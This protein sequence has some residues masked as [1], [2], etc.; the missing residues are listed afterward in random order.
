MSG[1]RSART[2]ATVSGAVLVVLLITV[3]ALAPCLEGLAFVPGGQSI[4]APAQRECEPGEVKFRGTTTA[5]QEATLLYCG[6]F[7]VEVQIDEIIDNRCG[8]LPE[9]QTISVFYDY[10]LPPTDPWL[11][12]GEK[13]EVLGWLHLPYGP[14]SCWGSVVAN[15][16]GEYIKRI[17]EGTPTPAPTCDPTVEITV[18]RGE[19]ATY[20]M[21]DPIEVCTQVSCPTHTYEEIYSII[22]DAPPT[23]ILSGWTT[24]KECHWFS[25]GEP[26]GVHRLRDETLEGATDETW[27][28]ASSCQEPTVTPTPTPVVTPEPTLPPSLEASPTATVT[29]GPTEAPTATPTVGPAPSPAPTATPTPAP[30]PDDG[31]GDGIPDA[32]DN[33]PQAWNASQYDLDE[34]GE[35]DVCDPLDVV[36][37]YGWEYVDSLPQRPD[38]NIVGGGLQY[39]GSTYTFTIKLGVPP[40]LEP[41]QV[42][43]GVYLDTDRSTTTGIR[44]GDL[45]ADYEVSLDRHWDPTPLLGTRWWCT[46]WNH[47]TQRGLSEVCPQ[48][49]VSGDTL[50][51]SVRAEDIGSPAELDYAFFIDGYDLMPDSG[52]HLSFVGEERVV[53]LSPRNVWFTWSEQVAFGRNFYDILHAD[54]AAYLPLVDVRI[55]LYRADGQYVDTLVSTDRGDDNCLWLPAVNSP[56]TEPCTTEFFSPYLEGGSANHAFVFDPSVYADGEYEVVATFEDAASVISTG[57]QTLIIDN[58]QDQNPPEITVHYPS[59]GTR[60]GWP[61]KLLFSAE[62][63][64]LIDPYEFDH[65]KALEERLK[66][67]DSWPPKDRVTEVGAKIVFLDGWEYLGESVN[68]AGENLPY[69][70]DDFGWSYGFIIPFA[71][72][73]GE[74]GTIKAW[75]K[76]SRGNEG[77]AEVSVMIDEC[78]YQEAW[79]PDVELEGCQDLD[80]D[81]VNGAE[82]CDDTDG[83]MKLRRGEDEDTD[84]VTNCDDLCPYASGFPEHEGCWDLGHYIDAALTKFCQPVAQCV[85][86]ESDAKACALSLAFECGLEAASEGCPETC[87]T[88]VGCA[89][90]AFELY[91]W[92]REAYCDIALDALDAITEGEWEKSGTALFHLLTLA[93]DVAND[94]PILG[95]PLRPLTIGITCTNGSTDVFDEAIEWLL[96]NA[97]R[98]GGW[99]DGILSYVHSPVELHAYDS[100]GRHVG[101]DE[102]GNIEERIPGAFYLRSEDLKVLWIPDASQTYTLEMRGTGSGTFSLV[103]QRSDERG[104]LTAEY[105]DVEVNPA[106]KATVT[107]SGEAELAMAVDVDGDGQTNQAVMPHSVE[108]DSDVDGIPNNVDRCPGTVAGVEVSTYGCEEGALRQPAWWPAGR[109]LAVYAAAKQTPL[110]LVEDWESTFDWRSE[111]DVTIVDDPKERYEKVAKLAVSGYAHGEQTASISREL[112]V[113]QGADI[114]AIPLATALNGGVSETDSEAGVEI[115]V[116]GKATVPTNVSH[117]WET[118]L[119]ASYILA[120]ADVSE[121]RGED[122]ELSI[123]LRQPDACAGLDC[124]HDVDLYVGDLFSASLPDVCTT[125]ADASHSLLDY[126]DDPTPKAVEECADPQPFYFQGVEYGPINTYGAGSD[127]HTIDF[128][129][130]EGATLDRMGL[131]Y[132]PNISRF[133]VNG[134]EI[135]PQLVYQAFPIRSSTYVAVEAPLKYAVANNDTRL[136]RSYLREGPN[137]ITVDV[138]SEHASDERPF[139]FYARFKVPPGRQAAWPGE[140]GMAPPVA[141]ENGGI[142]WLVPV[143]SVSAAAVAAALVLGWLVVRRRKQ[144]TPTG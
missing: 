83:S 67:E 97:T 134:E 104:L 80:G 49:A 1:L 99:S 18:D 24:G 136:L 34:D 39:D 64:D 112:T 75:A 128:E 100:Q 108:A 133:A 38:L 30:S 63:D 26:D 117:I 98:L 105:S 81:T 72:H 127:T 54:G 11:S 116:R 113:D 102:Q 87:A 69:W 3:G 47:S 20:C 48:D 4:A 135:D 37:H 27:F 41:G 122:V 110:A 130:P 21:G 44:V 125:E 12:A 5:D 126:Y 141:G 71:S 36:L 142:D 59:D 62:D 107:L 74:E 29:P 73:V 8:L 121:F 58:I 94:V 95:I 79:D 68:P 77:T 86:G 70:T 6:D 90:C 65:L 109:E 115:E 78:L 131:Y 28:S 123:T 9:G 76:D 57:K 32:I 35:G 56:E 7:R 51:I 50:Q 15:G 16:P 46:W 89:A 120:F 88:G 45:G 119:A 55:D 17:Q 91:D 19:G 31:D 14:V 114:V 10:L 13:V 25:V 124:T 144:P 84:G 85:P 53:P 143:V 93:Y 140:P 66:G 33:C 22:G 82:D 23:P 40:V 52:G 129:L 103:T 101:P 92:V 139:Y 43:Y 111:G 106:T 42:T 2:R 138:Q 96:K 118:K 60:F 132:G 61:A 137:T